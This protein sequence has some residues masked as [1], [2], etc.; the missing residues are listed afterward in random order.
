MPR[1]A[2]L[3]LAVALGCATQAPAPPLPS[4]G[5]TGAIDLAGTPG[6]TFPQIGDSS[7]R[8]G[9]ERYR[10]VADAP[11]CTPAVSA[12]FLSEAEVQTPI[13]SRRIQAVALRIPAGFVPAWYSRPDPQV[14]PE[15]PADS[16][17][18]WGH[19]LGSWEGPGPVTP[20]QRRETLS[21]WI[22][23]EDGYPTSWIGGAQARQLAIRECRLAT[24]AGTVSVALY[25]VQSS[26]PSFSGEFVAS[27][28]QLRPHVYVRIIG[29][30]PTSSGQ[31]ALLAA[32]A[33]MRVLQ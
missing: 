16:S 28:I 23:P 14:R 12:K 33:T 17:A 27:Y 26:E 29:V 9:S 11:P 10:A 4:A 20:L 1:A 18:H 5:S 25:S 31:A 13:P 8:L 3:L 30:S 2:L 7:R 22:G 6:A 24:P 21:I 19:L 32:M 15:D